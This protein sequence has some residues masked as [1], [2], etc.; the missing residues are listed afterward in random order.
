[1]AQLLESAAGAKGWLQIF[2]GGF[3]TRPV[4]A[5]KQLLLAWAWAGCVNAESG[6]L[7]PTNPRW[8]IQGP[9]G[10]P[11]NVTITSGAHFAV[12]QWEHAPPE[13]GGLAIHYTFKWQEKD[14]VDAT[15][16]NGWVGIGEEHARLDG[17]A[18]G[19]QY[20]GRIAAVNAYGRTWSDLVSFRTMQMVSCG[21]RWHWQGIIKE[22]DPVD[23][24]GKHYRSEDGSANPH[25]S[26]CSV[27]HVEYALA[28]IAAGLMIALL[29]GAVLARL[30]WAHSSKELFIVGGDGGGGSGR[31]SRI[32]EERLWENQIQLRRGGRRRGAMLLYA[33]A[34]RSHHAPYPNIQGHS[35]CHR[36]L[37]QTLQHAMVGKDEFRGT[38][39]P[40][41]RDASFGANAI[42]RECFS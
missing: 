16:F 29:A 12:L 4:G 37:T 24:C 35:S 41:R 22:D 7:D 5:G 28:G 21:D 20:G 23:L 19:A 38:E 3:F 36:Q 10:K 33:T 6:P 39:L 30:A 15:W 11:C 14:E 2:M 13:E 18:S 17:L 31:G 26:P 8:T 27:T 25:K 32:E 34:G 9:P 1:M 42:G 40:F